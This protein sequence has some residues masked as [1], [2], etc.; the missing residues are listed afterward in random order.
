MIWLSKSLMNGIE[1]KAMSL[2]KKKWLVRQESQ[3]SLIE[4]EQFL[5][6]VEEWVKFD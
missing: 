6:D 3:A 2:E 4:K 1:D 5:L